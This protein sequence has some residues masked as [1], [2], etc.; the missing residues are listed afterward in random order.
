MLTI[1]VYIYTINL[2]VYIN[3]CYIEINDLHI[4]K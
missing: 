4:D 3:S 2:A 1:V